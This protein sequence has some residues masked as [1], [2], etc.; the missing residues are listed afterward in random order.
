MFFQYKGKWYTKTDFNR[1]ER[2][3]VILSGMKSRCYN[4]DVIAYKYYG[5]KGINVCDDWLNDFE[6][7]YFWALENGY[8][9]G[10]TIDRIDVNGNYEPSNCRWVTKK[11]QAN[12]K[13]SNIYIDCY[14]EKLTAAQAAKKYNINAS[15]LRNEAKKPNFNFDDFIKTVYQK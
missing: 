10:L 13:T 8:Q 14:G 5:A 9:D 4:K 3:R 1:R 7:F 12:N 11:E 15:R 2:L 6:I